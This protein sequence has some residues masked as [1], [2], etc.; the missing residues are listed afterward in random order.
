MQHTLALPKQQESDWGAVTTSYASAGDKV[1]SSLQPFPPALP[2]YDWFSPDNYTHATLWRDKAL[3][4]IRAENL[5]DTQKHTAKQV[6]CF[7]M[8]AL[9]D[10][11]H[12]DRAEC[13][14]AMLPNQLPGPIIK[15]RWFWPVKKAVLQPI[16]L[17]DIPERI[18]RGGEDYWR[19]M[20]PLTWSPDVPPAVTDL[21]SITSA[22]LLPDSL[23]LVAYRRHPDP[24]IYA[25]Y[26]L[27]YLKIAE[28]T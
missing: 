15:R 1:K 24:M 5:S 16:R 14:A 25:Q 11:Y 9:I 20:S 22:A 28:W 2:T 7:E 21:L 26:G 23:Q 19:E 12:K 17:A 8:N 18:T 3:Q 6:L 10:I 4:V 13:V 27:W